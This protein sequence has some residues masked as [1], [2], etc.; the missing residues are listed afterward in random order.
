MTDNLT[1]GVNNMPIDYKKIEKELYQ[2]KTTPSII[3]VPEMTYITVDGKGNPN[4]SEAYKTAIEMLYGLSYSIKMSKMSGSIPTGYF[5]YV[6]PPLEGLWWSID[7]SDKD[8]FCWTAMIRQPEF[9]TPEVF[10]VAKVALAKKKTGLDLSKARLEKI[11]EGL[12]VQAM[13]IGSYDNESATIAAME[14]Y[15]TEKGYIIDISDTR[16]HHEIYLSDPQKVAIDKLKTVIRYPI[17]K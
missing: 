12:C 5:E 6:V 1:S 2:P 11:T 14:Q 3:D 13:H 15:A 7:Y 16:R 10:D 4:T 17:R 8:N 9:V